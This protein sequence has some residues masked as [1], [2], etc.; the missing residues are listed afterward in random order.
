MAEKIKILA[1][2]DPAVQ[3]Y[4][5]AKFFEE[6]PGKTQLDILPWSSYYPAMM[7]SLEGRKSLPGRSLLNENRWHVVWK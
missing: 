4:V 6:Y 3:G 5:K 1:V 7:D 2:A